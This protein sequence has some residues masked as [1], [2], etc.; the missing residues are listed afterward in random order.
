M[1]QVRNESLS[2][3]IRN[4]YEDD[5]Y[6]ARCPH[7]RRQTCTAGAQDYVGSHPHQ[8]CC[9]S[10]NPFGVG[11]WPAQVDAKILP[12]PPAQPLKRLHKRRDV[13]PVYWVAFCAI[14]QHA[15][16][17]YPIGRLRARNE[18]PSN[19]RAA[20]KHDEFAAFH[21]PMPP[22]LPTDRIAHLGT[23]GDCCAAG[24]HSS[25]WRRRAKT[26][27]PGTW[28]LSPGDRSAWW[29]KPIFVLP[30][31]SA[32]RVGDSRNAISAHWQRG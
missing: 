25:L 2:Y 28:R 7:Q 15:D 24:F 13:G 4:K 6:A 22:V 21:C 30:L 9:V 29:R 17:A 20:K 16:P 18:R 31:L 11:G 32:R 12:L 27:A 26:S 1:C 14:H 5:L 23:A 8:P 3:R 19:R 10:T